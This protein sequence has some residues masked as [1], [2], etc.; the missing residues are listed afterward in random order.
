MKNLSLIDE[1]Y[2][3]PA[4]C[5]STWTSVCY[6]ASLLRDGLMWRIGNDASA[7]FWT[8]LWFDCGVLREYALDSS[9]VD[10]DML[11]QDFWINSKWDKVLLFAY[12]PMDIVA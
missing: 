1:S 6:G 8:D 3:K 10:T 9:M 4:T 2:K 11:V 5:S 12:L 7:H